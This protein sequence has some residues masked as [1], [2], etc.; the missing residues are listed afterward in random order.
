MIQLVKSISKLRQSFSHYCFL[1]MH[2]AQSHFFFH[3]Q[4][5]ATST[6]R[7]P[8]NVSLSFWLRLLFSLELLLLLQKAS[9]WVKG[10]VVTE[11]HYTGTGTVLGIVSVAPPV[12]GNCTCTPGMQEAKTDPSRKK[13][14]GFKHCCSFTQRRMMG[15][16]L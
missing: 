1:R 4:Y 2:F 14:E 12:T 13:H 10:V 5:L 11:G 16:D 7:L 8:N 15:V 3:V 6:Y 9:Q